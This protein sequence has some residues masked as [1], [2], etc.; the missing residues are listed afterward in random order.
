[1]S[2]LA[3]GTV[4]LLVGTKRGLFVLTSRDRVTWTVERLALPGTRVFNAVYDPRLGGRVFAADNGDFFGTF[5]RYSDDLGET[6]HEPRQ[7]I[8]FAEDSGQS[9]KNIWI[10][11]PGRASEPET[12]Y[13]G[14][15]PASLWVS[16][17][18]GETWEIVA[19]LRHHPT[20]DRWQPGA[21]GL[22]L[23]SIV[24]DHA[25]P[26]RMW[27]GISAVG[28]MRSDDGGATWRHA[29]ANT[30]ADFLPDPY[31]EYGQCIHRLIQ[32]PERPDTLYQQNHCG[33]YASI[34]GGDGW[35]DIQGG[36]PSPFG[37]PIALDP[38]HPD[39]LF[40]VVEDGVG[41]YNFPDTFTVYRSRDAGG[42]WE[43]LTDGL[44]SG[45]QVRLGVLRHGMCTD[46]LDP[47]GVYVGTNTGQLFVSDDR[48]DHWNLVAD[49]LPP[50][51]SVS[52]AVA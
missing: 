24:L 13:L 47:C 11:Q 1:M 43:A 35:T 16:R 41:R 9:L 19:G 51:Y 14:V 5:L 21:G 15:D 48:G 44:P 50:I 7:G 40:T 10:V 36:L 4:F 20:R 38:H 6:W 3:S 27:V 22:C 12:L 25:D 26:E 37:F 30:R 46:A 31:P 39:T 33:V 49:F 29:N 52:V 17:D 32:H 18:G 45:K 8:R 23:H 34:D 2:A 28:C 42:S